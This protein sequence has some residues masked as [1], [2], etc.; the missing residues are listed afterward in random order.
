ML[1]GAGV[2]KKPCSVQGLCPTEW[3]VPCCLGSSEGC[4]LF[5]KYV[6]GCDRLD[7]GGPRRAVTPCAGH[8]TEPERDAQLCLPSHN[9][10]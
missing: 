4:W 9:G 2:I 1:A 6:G 3:C 10:V 8:A 5:L 7:H